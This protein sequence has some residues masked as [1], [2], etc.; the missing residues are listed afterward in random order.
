MGCSARTPRMAARMSPRR[1]LGPRQVRPAPHHGPNGGPPNIPQLPKACC[2]RGSLCPA[3][4][5][6]QSLSEPSGPQRPA[7]R[8]HGAPI[9][10]APV[11]SIT[12]FR[13]VSNRYVN[14]I[15]RQVAEQE[16]R[17]VLP[18]PF[19]PL[20]EMWPFGAKRGVVTMTRMYDRVVAEAIEDLAFKIIHQRCE[21]LR[22][23][24]LAR[25]TGKQAVSSEKVR[26][27]RA[28]V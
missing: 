13:D 10:C 12:C 1:A 22:T 18:A 28:C 2:P 16:T 27:T 6:S 8:S 20:V 23:R 9:A 15:S 26:S 19:P 5:A 3:I 21:V 11:M 24:G 7:K 4:L 17:S 14:D 25:P